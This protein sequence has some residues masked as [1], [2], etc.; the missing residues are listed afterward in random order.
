M[1]DHYLLVTTLRT[2]SRKVAR[3]TIQKTKPKRRYVLDDLK[4]SLGRTE[5]VES[6][7]RV[8]EDV[9]VTVPPRTERIHDKILVGLAE[10]ADSTLPT[11]NRS[12]G[13]VVPWR[14]DA[15]LQALLE[16]RD[17]AR[18]S[19]PLSQQTKSLTRKVRNRAKWLRTQYY[20]GEAEAINQFAV[21]REVEREPSYYQ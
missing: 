19:D 17:R 6:V 21:N 9:L 14:N 12:K 15:G 16:Q 11:Q 20:R 2:P 8:F 4:C 5:F 3:A 7:Q 13:L 18:K 10:S 1:S